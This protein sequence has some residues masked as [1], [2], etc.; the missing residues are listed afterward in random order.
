[1]RITDRDNVEVA[2]RDGAVP[3]GHKTAIVPILQG[4]PIIKYGAP[5]GYA[6]RD[7]AEGEH[8]HTHNTATN[9]K[10]HQTY[11]YEPV[12][13][14][15]PRESILPK[16]FPGYPRRA[17]NSGIRNEIWILPTVGCVN[18]IG[19]RIASLAS[20]KLRHREPV[21]GIFCFPHPY[22]CSQLG[23]DKENTERILADL[24][25]HPNA[26]GVLV[27]GL[28]C[29]NS[30][31]DSIRRWI[32]PELLYKVDFLNAQDCENEIQEGVDRVLNLA[33]RAAADERR[34][35][36]ISELVV[37]LKCG[38]SDGLSGITANPLVGRFSDE[39]IAAGG[40]TILTEV[41]EM[42]GAESNLLNR[43]ADSTVFQEAVT[44]IDSFKDY[45][46]RY[47]QTVYENPSPGN[48]AGGITTLEDKSLGCTQKSGTAP[49]TGV[50]PYGGRIRAAGLH[51]LSA[52][53]NDLVASTAL[54]CAG[55]QIILFT[56]GR[57]TPFGVPAPTIKISSNT[58]L[59]ERKKGW[60]D[61]NAGPIAESG[62]FE[63]LLPELCDLVLAVAAGKRT[64]S[65]QNSCREIAIFKDGVTL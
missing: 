37:G 57:G 60:I 36:P 59:F 2:L 19:E 26:G 35:V 52:P 39:L 34:P 24:A 51:L 64:R 7:I 23:G 41:P 48:K 62:S 56:T 28:G 15:P 44:M 18:R 42:F 47:G 1:M 25:M 33:T 5:I 30:G 53:G 49:V 32:D 61:L 3:M 65:E 46:L 54:T 63:E 50:L 11:R 17:G 40:T 20:E 29:E 4:A 14:E 27:L 43:C 45:F 31:I 58:P 21:D 22:G 9:L 55:A 10:E 13:I 6:T 12:S 8:V 16:T 38:G